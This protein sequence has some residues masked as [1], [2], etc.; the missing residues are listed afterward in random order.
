MP[1]VLAGNK[2]DLDFHRVDKAEL[3]QGMFQCDLI[4]PAADITLVLCVCAVA[5]EWNC[6]ALLTSAKTKVNNLEIFY[7]CVREIIR[8]REIGGNEEEEDG[9]KCHCTS[10]CIVL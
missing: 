4:S 6:P 9:K 10:G 3:D 5:K 1:I 7:Q 8:Y 2:C